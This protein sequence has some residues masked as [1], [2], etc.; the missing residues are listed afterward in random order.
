MNHVLLADKEYRYMFRCDLP[1]ESKIFANLAATILTKAKHRATQPT[2]HERIA[3]C[4]DDAQRN[5]SLVA[6]L[7][8]RYDYINDRKIRVEIQ[9]YSKRQM[10]KNPG[11]KL[12]QAEAYHHLGVCATASRK[13]D[14]AIGLFEDSLRV[15]G[16][17]ESA[18][19]F[20]GTYTAVYLC[21]LHVIRGQPDKGE[22]VLKPTLEKHEEIVGTEDTTYPE[23]A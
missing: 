2:E 20:A 18:R 15:Y 1:S 16:E 12:A 19:L 5:L 14:K 17:L 6:C 21:L 23:Y 22:E 7:N 8:G 9:A 4:L 13:I 3:D 11:D 10:N